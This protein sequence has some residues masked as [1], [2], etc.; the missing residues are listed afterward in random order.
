M[1][2]LFIFIYLCCVGKYSTKCHQH[3]ILMGN[4]YTCEIQRKQAHFGVAPPT[5]HR[6]HDEIVATSLLKNGPPF[7][8][9]NIRMVKNQWLET[10]ATCL[11][12]HNG[13]GR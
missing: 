3:K 2:D 12:S 6:V 4:G 13:N 1:I 9:Q 7:G 5:N 8:C 11:D 10:I